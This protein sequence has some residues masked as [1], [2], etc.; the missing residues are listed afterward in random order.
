MLMEKLT[1]I[2]GKCSTLGWY[3]WHCFRPQI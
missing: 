3:W 1:E 2:K